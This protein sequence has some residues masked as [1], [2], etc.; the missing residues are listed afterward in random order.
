MG[1]PEGTEVYIA[2]WWG[3]RHRMHQLH[4]H[5]W[6]RSHP[7]EGRTCLQSGSCA[8]GMPEGMVLPGFQHPTCI[9]HQEVWP[10]RK[11]TPPLW[12]DHG[13]ALVAPALFQT[14]GSLWLATQMQVTH[15]QAGSARDL[16]HMYTVKIHC[17]G[18]SAGGLTCP[19][20]LH[21]V[22]M[23]VVKHHIWYVQP[24]CVEVCVSDGFGRICEQA[25]TSSNKPLPPILLHTSQ[26]N[27]KTSRFSKLPNS[28]DL[29]I[30]LVTMPDGALAGPHLWHTR[31]DVGTPTDISPA[32]LSRLH[33]PA[34]DRPV[35]V[36]VGRSCTASRC[37]I[38]TTAGNAYI[39]IQMM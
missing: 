9:T 13:G 33:A 35:Q 22:V 15:R 21:H 36:Q 5:A 25:S 31:S 20:P 38:C 26:D 39:D 27:I 37:P 3:P 18:V 12:A 17:A 2:G 28:R 1:A 16:R 4:A 19:E 23:L 8:G 29:D 6:L 32:S 10:A 24:Y 7:S 11:L 34:E 30:K 14:P